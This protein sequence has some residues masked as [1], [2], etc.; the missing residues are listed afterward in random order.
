MTAERHATWMRLRV[1]GKTYREIGL[2]EGVSPNTVHEAV[3]R[4]LRETLAEPAAELR[5]LEVERVEGL[6]AATL[7][8]VQKGDSFA[9]QTAVRVLESKRKLLG[10]DAPTKT[11]DVTP[12][13]EQLLEQIRAALQ[14]PPPELAAV[15]AETGWSRN[16]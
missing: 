1:Q 8:K 2:L 16:L 9:I 3:T 6:Y 4:R 7:P 12:P 10:I 15:L 11:M 5:T 14:S 13:K